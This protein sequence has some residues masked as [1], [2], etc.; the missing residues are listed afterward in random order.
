M[1]K[2]GPLIVG[3]LLAA[4]SFAFAR[5]QYTNKHTAKVT[6][7]DKTATATNPFADKNLFGD[8]IKDEWIFAIAIPVACLAG[9]AV[10]AAK[11]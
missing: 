10:L 6:I 3:L 7:G 1:K 9:G 8:W 4:G 11:K 2:L 5:Y